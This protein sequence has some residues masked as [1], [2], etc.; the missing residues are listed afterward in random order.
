MAMSNP[1]KSASL[2]SLGLLV[3]L[4]FSI[5][6]VQAGQD[7]RGR[8]RGQARGARKAPSE[9]SEY[10][11]TCDHDGNSW[12]S[13]REASYSLLFD[14][15]QYGRADGNND[16]RITRPEFDVYYANTQASLGTF[17]IPR[18]MTG[19]SDRTANSP[20]TPKPPKEATVV[21]AQTVSTYFGTH[22]P[23]TEDGQG[24]VLP[25]QIRGPV[26]HFVRL[27]I[28]GDGRIT[29][30]DLEALERPLHLNIRFSSVIAVLD[31]DNDGG[32]TRSEFYAAM[33]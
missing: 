22:H 6:A 28:N 25:P 29:T 27:D 15:A 32:V 30:K 31:R 13:F 11:K 16:G 3:A 4:A 1:L 19:A 2:L 24:A 8:G 12:I 7:G 26:H 9:Q 5:S 18:A 20:A 21:N 10:F 23:R 14:R 33:R 17:P